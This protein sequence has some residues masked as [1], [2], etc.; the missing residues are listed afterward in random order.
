ML[1]KLLSW[2]CYCDLRERVS[3]ID[4]ASPEEYQVHVQYFRDQ[5]MAAAENHWLRNKVLDLV[6]DDLTLANCRAILKFL[7]EKGMVETE[8]EY[9]VSRAAAQ[10]ARQGGFRP[11]DQGEA[12]LSGD[13]FLI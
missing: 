1:N 9:E 7:A 8:Q 11:D 13:E 12:L 10:A 6:A 3:E 5:I 4:E 2:S